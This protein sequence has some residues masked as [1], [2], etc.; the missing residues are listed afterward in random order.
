MQAKETEAACP[1]DRR[2]TSKMVSEMPRV[3][4]I[5]GK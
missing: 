5:S 1:I 4:N 2:K 3:G